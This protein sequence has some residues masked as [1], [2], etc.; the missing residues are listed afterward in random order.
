MRNPEQAGEAFS[1]LPAC[2][3]YRHNSVAAILFGDLGIAPARVILLRP[4]AICKFPLLHLLMH[5]L[6]HSAQVAHPVETLQC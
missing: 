1:V 6:V 5:F 3:P 4:E 2:F